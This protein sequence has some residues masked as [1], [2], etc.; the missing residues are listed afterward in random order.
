MQQIQRHNTQ[1]V[2]DAARFVAKAAANG[3]RFDVVVIDVFDD[4]SRPPRSVTSLEFA[5]VAVFFGV[6]DATGDK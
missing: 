2:D 1:V 5:Y 6:D 4:K 3:D